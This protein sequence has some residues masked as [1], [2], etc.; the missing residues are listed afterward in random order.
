MINI[1]KYKVTRGVKLSRSQVTPNDYNPNETT[2]TQQK[3]INESLTEYGQLMEIVVRPDPDNEGKYLIVD[4]EHRYQELEDEFYCNIVHGLSEVDAKKLTIIFNETRGQA[5]KIKLATLL[6]ELS[7]SISTED[8][9]VGLPYDSSELE[10]LLAISKIN[11]EDYGSSAAPPPTSSPSNPPENSTSSNP[12]PDFDY[13]DGNDAG[14][15]EF[16]TLKV[17]KEDF[18]SVQDCFDMVREE[19]EEENSDKFLAWGEVL[20]FLSKQ[21]LNQ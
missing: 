15:Y 3:A 9:N 16:I 20:L 18:Q 10:E 12:A 13:G 11:W 5:D 2:K 4:G 19:I 21:W 8:L 6:N 14:E 17:L 1:D 7:A